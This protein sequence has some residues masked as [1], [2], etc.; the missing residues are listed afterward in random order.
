MPPIVEENG[1]EDALGFFLCLARKREEVHHK[2]AAIHANHE[3]DFEKT[4]PDK[5]WEVGDRVWV[6]NLPKQEDGDFEKLARIWLGPCKMLEIMGEGRYPV[7]TSQGPL[8]LGIGRLKLAV[9]LR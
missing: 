1:C 4:Q 3:N 8:I 6:R 9:P 2:L 5:Q 7:A